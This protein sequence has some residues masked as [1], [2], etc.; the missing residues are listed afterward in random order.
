MLK[1]GHAQNGEAI[2][3]QISKFSPRMLSAAFCATLLK[4]EPGNAVQGWR[5]TFNFPC[6]YP[7]CIICS[8]YWSSFDCASQSYW[9]KHQ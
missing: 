1:N 8:Y 9:P 4:V 2:F 6:Y 5:D 3:K 7:K